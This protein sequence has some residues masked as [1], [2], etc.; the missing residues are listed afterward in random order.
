MIEFSHKQMKPC[1]QPRDALNRAEQE[2]TSHRAAHGESDDGQGADWGDE[3][4]RLLDA[5]TDAIGVYEDCVRANDAHLPA[6]P[7][8]AEDVAAMSRMRNSEG[9]AADG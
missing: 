4:R 8:I 1:A 3:R 7:D 9:A 2:L 5:V 6:R